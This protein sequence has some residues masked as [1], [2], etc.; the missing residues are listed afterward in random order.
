MDLTWLDSNSWLIEMAGQRI[1]LDP[2]LVGPLVF[3]DLP[4]LFKAERLVPRRIPEQIDLILLS[5]GLVDHAHPPT[6]RQLDPNI[7]VL[8]SA[9]AAKVVTGL[10]FT[11]VIALA[12]GEV[13]TFNNKIRLRATP[14]SWIGPKVRE[15][16][17]LLTDLE[18]DHSLYYEPHGSHSA[19][20]QAFAPVQVVITPLID[21]SLL[22]LPVLTGGNAALEVVKWLQPQFILPTAAGGEVKLSGFLNA[23]LRETRDCQDFQQLL[24][25]HQLSTQVL[26]PRPGDRLH[27]ALSPQAPSGRLG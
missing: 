1:L 20:L 27:L 6:L 21:L 18:T 4:W 25:Q 15:N 7:P 8:A 13:F 12:P 19:S 10:G 14:G 23:L 17:Y 3:G 11:Q 2:W 5:Q 9:N 24:R 16:G 26:D 22:G